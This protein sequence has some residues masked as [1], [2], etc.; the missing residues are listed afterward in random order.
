MCPRSVSEQL[1]DLTPGDDPHKG[2]TT[3]N[4]QNFLPRL[5]RWLSAALGL[6][7]PVAPHTEWRRLDEI[8]PGS[9]VIL[10]ALLADV[11]LNA[12][13]TQL[14]VVV[15]SSAEVLQSR[16]RGPV[17][18]RARSTLVAIGREEANKILVE[19]SS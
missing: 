11:E 2:G 3:S 7:R 9:R 8:E 16:A 4:S 5:R 1:S 19:T 6:G 12:R 17:L 18:I 10:C 13:L 15:G 14:G